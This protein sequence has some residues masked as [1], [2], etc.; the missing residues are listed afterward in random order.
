MVFN[1]K[2]DTLEIL[3]FAIKKQKLKETLFNDI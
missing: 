1:F 2:N 3:R